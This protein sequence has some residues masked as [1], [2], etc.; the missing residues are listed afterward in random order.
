[1]KKI[2]MFF[3]MVMTVAVLAACGQTFDAAG[4]VRGSL[5]AST[6]GEFKE[7]M[8]LTDSTEKEAKKMYNDNLDENVEMFDSFGLS[9]DLSGKYRDL[10]KD[11]Y[12]KTRYTVGEAKE[13]K[14]K[15]YTVTVDIE[16]LLVFEDL[17]K[18]LMAYQETYVAKVQEEVL[19]GKE[20]PSEEEMYNAIYTELYNMLKER[21]EKPEYGKKE[22]IKVKVEKHSDNTYEIPDDELEKIDEKLIDIESAGF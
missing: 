13:D 5:D 1:M 2:S 14:E 4:Y 16:P 17:Q 10:F 19:A 11:M 15:N 9:S 20:M 21:L 6:K 3:A 8:K 7:Y 12:K 18:D 22:T